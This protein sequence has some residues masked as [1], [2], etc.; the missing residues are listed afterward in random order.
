M[1]LAMAGSVGGK[2]AR[3]SCLLTEKTGGAVVATATLEASADRFRRPGLSTGETCRGLSLCYVSNVSVDSEH[4]RRGLATQLLEQAEKTALT[5]GCRTMLLHVD[6][7]EKGGLSLYKRAGYR[8]VGL[9]PPWMPLV[10]LRPSVRLL[11]MA[12][13]VKGTR[14]R[15]A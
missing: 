8:T 2:G 14:R 1:G 5:W 7:A 6:S 10:Q 13:R 12:K 3:S 9:E 4:R 11:L 15:E